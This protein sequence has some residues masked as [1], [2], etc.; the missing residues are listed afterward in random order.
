MKSPVPIL[1]AVCA[2]LSIGHSRSPS[3]PEDAAPP[4]ARTVIVLRHAEKDT[5][6]KDPRDPP[7]SAAGAVR[8]QELARLLGASGATH[9][10]TSDLARTRETLAPLAARLALVSEAV[11]AAQ[12]E[13]VVARLDALPAGSA[14]VVCGHSNTVPRIAE[15][16]GVKLPG[17]VE[18]QGLPM[19]ADDSYDRVF[20]IT[21]PA[22]GP[23][24]CLELRYGAPSGATSSAGK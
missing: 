6:A 20:V 10:Y 1:L 24:A 7:L 9:L 22:I 23:A 16:L 3:R 11:P 12:P 14:A 18:V 15:L 4:A 17:L 13:E 2:L 5:A 21:R 19:L 8:A